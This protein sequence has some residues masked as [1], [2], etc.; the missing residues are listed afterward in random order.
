MNPDRADAR[1]PTAR[2]A[3]YAAAVLLALSLLPGTPRAAGD[4][5]LQPLPPRIFFS[6]PDEEARRE[7]DELLDN[8]SGDVTKSAEAREILVRRYGL[9]AVPQLVER[10]EAGNNEA[11]V[12]NAVLTI[13]SLRRRLGPSQHLW[14]AIRPLTTLL[15]KEGAEPWRRAF[16]ALALG[17]F[18][19]PDTARRGGGSHEGTE[20]GAAKAREALVEGNA[21]L[22]WATSDANAT[23]SIAASIALGKIGGMTASRLRAEHRRSSPPP[24][25]P[26]AELAELLAIG[27][28][29]HDEDARLLQALKDE[30]RRVRAAAA[31]AIAC[32]AVA[33]GG[34]ATGRALAAVAATRAAQFDPLLHPAHN[35][36]LRPGEWDGAEALFARGALAHVTR[37]ADAWEELY[38]AALSATE[39]R[40]AVAAAQALLFAP[41]GAPARARIAEI[42]GRTNFARSVREPVVAGFL[43]IAGSDGTPAGVRSCRAF[44]RDKSREPRGRLEYDVRYH[45]A[46]ALVRALIAGRVPPE[47]RADAVDALSEAVRVALPRGEG[48]TFRS[49]LA[50]V[51]AP[52]E[53]QFAADPAARPNPKAPAL[54]EAA[55]TDPDALLAHD[56]V[57]VTVDRLNDAVE[58]LFGLDSVSKAASGPPGARTVSRDDVPL[59]LLQG[60]LDAYPYFARGDLL[61]DRGRVAA[62]APDPGRNPELEL[63][64]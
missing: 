61:R 5:D 6:Q 4:D 7:I 45:A 60:W 15:R 16:A 50:D 46:V 49:A 44:L 52:F 28:M 19:G 58:F 13:G 57:D 1:R 36:A 64:R 38:Q 31:L 34:E 18:Y 62:R 48:R 26:E 21:A 42:V 25:V 54:L 40:P 53:K 33:Q 29:P 35:S 23:V 39:Q 43:V 12:R 56:L 17:T 11:I 3:A 10:I 59:R 47:A 51:V 27:L 20:A 22:V 41:Q 55:F 8:A 63:D 9:W 24:A 14:P 2:K 30:D 37:R 32:W